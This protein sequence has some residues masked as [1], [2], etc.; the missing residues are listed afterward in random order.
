MKFNHSSALVASALSAL[1]AAAPQARS[2]SSNNTVT[3]SSESTI[4]SAVTCRTIHG[5]VSHK[6]VSTTET[7]IHLEPATSVVTVL[8]TATSTVT[9]DIETITST[10]TDTSTATVTES[11]VTDTFST[12]STVVST[13]TVTD[14]TTE[15]STTEAAS[16]VTSTETATSTVPAPAGF[17]PITDSSGYSDYVSTK[18]QALQRDVRLEAGN[19]TEQSPYA[20]NDGALLYPDNVICATEIHTE[21]V[22]TTTV[23]VST[24]TVTAPV[25]TFTASATTTTTSTSTVVPDD[26]S[27]TLSFTSTSTEV[28]TTTSTATSVTTTTATAIVTATETDYAA[29]ATP[30][31][32]GPR[33][34]DGTYITSGQAL[35]G[36]ELNTIAYTSAY[37]CCVA[38]Q[39]LTSCVYAHALPSY[40]CYVV[41]A[42]DSGN[43]VAGAVTSNLYSDVT[44]I[45]GDAWVSNEQ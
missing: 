39:Q 33:I 13:S 18:R 19:S 25:E 32:L 20:M 41:T 5:T 12:T 4:S 17:T 26:V 40:A 16:V 35:I 15:I 34:N 1:V 7:S 2:V 21:V 8:T 30:N 31:I 6:C 45:Y 23:V 27:T 11:T 14:T 44:A 28:T 43:C 24:A 36:I 37:D 10:A 3:G 42:R 29:C 9:P 22:Q 38:C